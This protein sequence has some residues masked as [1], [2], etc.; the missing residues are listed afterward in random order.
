MSQHKVLFAGGGT[1]GHLMP[2]I[3][4]A[5]QM[6]ELDKSIE[7]LFI[8]KKGGME[9]AIVSKFGF[10][11]REI[12]VTSLKR[13]LGGMIRFLLNWRKGFSQA[14]KIIRDFNP[15]LV[16]GSGGYVSAPVVRAAHKCG[17]PIYLQEQNSLPGLATRSLGKLATL[18]FTAYEKASDYLPRDKCR[19][20]GNPLRPDILN[21]DRQSSK[22]EF[23]LDSSKKILLVLGGSSGA[24]A[25]NRAI[26]SLVNTDCI[27]PTWQ[28]LWQTGEKDF[29]RIKSLTP[30]DKFRGQSLPFIYN[31]P[32]AYSSA[33][34]IISRAGAMA[35]AEIAAWGIPSILI[36][37]PF[38]TG[39]HQTLNAQQ[40]AKASAAILIP[41]TEIESRLS[42][43][44]DGLFNND[45]K[46]SNM[47]EEAKK[48]ARIDATKMIA[49]TILEKINEIQK[50]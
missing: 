41:E 5:L 25:I 38:A 48:L 37:F 24:Q 9:A 22:R 18:I 29:E 20:V 17:L 10:Q 15:I 43:T 16:I 44:L 6:T 23:G 49:E 8:G 36:P 2:A 11:I 32:A 50:N 7:S 34:L 19:M 31:M 26:L 12:E 42:L 4:I 33:D 46:R 47:A 40:F 45:K 1:A 28:I 13:N 39:D 21:A 14:M 30:G 27:P 3:N 35:L